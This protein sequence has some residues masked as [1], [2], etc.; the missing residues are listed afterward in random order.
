MKKTILVSLLLLISIL[1]AA[2]IPDNSLHRDNSVII[3]QDSLDGNNISA[4]IWDSGVFD[5]D[6]RTTNTPGFYWPKN[7]KKAA[8]FTAGLTISAYVN[9]QIRMATASY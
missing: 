4:M 3:R 8:L 1:F 9:N 6:L 2:Y 5:Q 7:S